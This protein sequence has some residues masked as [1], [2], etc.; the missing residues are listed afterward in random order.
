MIFVLTVLPLVRQRRRKRIESA[1]RTIEGKRE[2]TKARVR[3]MLLQLNK[4][5]RLVKRSVGLVKNECIRQGTVQSKGRSIL[6]FLK[7]SNKARDRKL[8]PM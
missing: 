2:M 6:F 7:R 8:L 3:W 5:S 4:A 1:R